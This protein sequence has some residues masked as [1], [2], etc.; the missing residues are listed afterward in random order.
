TATAIESFQP[1]LLIAKDYY[2]FGMEMSGR[3]GGTGGTEPLDE[4]RYGFQGQ[5]KDD[6]ITG[7]TG[8]HLNFK[9]RMYDARIGRFFAIDPLAAKYAYNSTY[10]F[11][12]NRVIDGV[13]LEGLEWF[14]LDGVVDPNTGERGVILT[15]SNVNASDWRVDYNK[16][17]ISRLPGHFGIKQVQDE[18]GGAYI[19]DG[20]LIMT[21]VNGDT[22][23]AY[24]F[25]EVRPGFYSNDGF[26]SLIPIGDEGVVMEG[27]LNVELY[28]FSKD[29][30]STPPKSLEQ[31]II[32]IPTSSTDVH[33]VVSCSNGGSIP[34]DF[35]I[36][37]TNTGDILWENDGSSDDFYIPS[38]GQIQVNI[39][40]DPNEEEDT[41]SIDI[42]VEF[43]EP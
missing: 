40:G 38:G 33:V 36:T 13:E 25:R 39:Y 15:V 42:S 18:W 8:S 24:K 21:D 41:F 35:S 27:T 31:H 3:Y 20:N 9:Y 17:T 32:N 37:D 7:Q 28:T 43:T 34:N 1:E 22:Y 4:Y 12:E 23:S 14:S 6:E 29:D 16:Q 19:N 30:Q 11:S 2:P 10:A 26:S 5:E